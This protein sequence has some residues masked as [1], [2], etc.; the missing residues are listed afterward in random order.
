MAQS[1]FVFSLRAFI[2]GDFS[3]IRMGKFLYFFVGV[4]VVGCGLYH[5]GC[6]A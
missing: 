5:V 6:G 4:G 2:A 1:I 3:Y